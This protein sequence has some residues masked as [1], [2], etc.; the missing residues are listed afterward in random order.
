MDDVAMYA[1]R[2]AVLDRGG[3]YLAGA[4]EDVF[5]RGE[6]LLKMGLD[7]P[8]ATRLVYA[9]R[10]RGVELEHNYYRMDELTDALIRRWNA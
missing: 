6:D 9:L 8:Q 1:D 10:A 5:S 7:L 4:P 2:I 3:L